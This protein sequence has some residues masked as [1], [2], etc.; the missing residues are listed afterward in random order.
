MFS[1]LDSF[2][3]D[4]NDANIKVELKY[5]KVDYISM[6]NIFIDES[7]WGDIYFSWVLNSE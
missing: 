7:Y 2:F 1:R 4:S 3:F 6:A 5:V